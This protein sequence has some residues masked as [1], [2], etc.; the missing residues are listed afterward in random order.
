MVIT[1]TPSTMIRVSASIRSRVRKV[2]GRKIAKISAFH[3]QSHF[4]AASTGK[5]APKVVSPQ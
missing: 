3:T 4:A 2:S 5:S 1:A